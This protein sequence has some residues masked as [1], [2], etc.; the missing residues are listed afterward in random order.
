LQI[1]KEKEINMATLDFTVIPHDP[2]AAAAGVSEETQ[3]L[4]RVAQD[5]ADAAEGSGVTVQDIIDRIIA[6]DWGIAFKSASY[7]GT[8]GGDSVEVKIRV[9]NS[10]GVAD[11]FAT[12]D[13]VTVSLSGSAT[14]DETNPVEFVQ[15]RVGGKLVYEATIHVSDAVAEAVTASLTD[16]EAT[17]LDVSSTST[18]TFS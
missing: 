15:S 11:P 12:I 8:A 13:G 3:A 9:T 4:F 18:I 1:L 2:D 10:T 14:M 16:S 5:L 7:A 6:E 17:G